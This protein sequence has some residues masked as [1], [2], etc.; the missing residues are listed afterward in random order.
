MTGNRNDTPLRRK[1][2]ALT[3]SVNYA[4]YLECIAPNIRHFDRWLIVTDE[5]DTRTQEVC[6]RW[7]MEILLSKRLY[8]NGAVFHKAAALNEGLA[9]LDQD[10]WVAVMDSDILLPHD[11]RSRLDAQ[12]L[13][14][15]CLYGLGGRRICQTIHDFQTLAACEPWADNLIYTTFVIGYF[16]LFHLGQEKNRYPEES[17]DDAS[18]YDVDFSESFAAARRRYL[19][20]V[21]LHAGDASQNWRGRVTDPFFEEGT[22]RD[23]VPPE[24]QSEKI[25]AMLGGPRTTAVQIGCYR[26]DLTRTLARSFASVV[27]IDH[28]G[29]LVSSPSPALAIDL[30]LLARRYTSETKG[31]TNITPPLEHSDETLATIAD[32]SL[33]V[34]WLT[35]EPEY[36]FLLNFLPAW[37][38]KLKPG[39]SIVGG[40]YDPRDLPGP[41]RVVHLLLGP[42]DETF[43]DRQWIRHLGEP[44]QF[45]AER[46][47]QPLSSLPRQ[48]VIYVS[49][50]EHDVEALLVSLS[51]LRRHWSGA[52]CVLCAGDENPS[53]RLACLKLNVEFRNVPCVSENYPEDLNRLHALE[54]SPFEE[55]VFIDANTLVLDSPQF[56]FEALAEHD[57][58]FC[59][60]QGRTLAPAAMEA[61]AWHRR[62]TV[63]DSWRTIAAA[64][65]PLTGLLATSHGIGALVNDSALHLLPAESLWS[66]PAKR[67]PPGVRILA[68]PRLARAG[69]LHLY[70][71]WAEQEQAL[72][73]SMA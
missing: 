65:L 64:M 4:D 1:I 12:H 7:G 35:A 9:A 5:K 34:I 71:L 46:F 67:M 63:I 6:R 14:P 53:L 31:L 15:A 27:V 22:L 24:P 43:P 48:G 59:R 30:E 25:A 69:A 58:G 37:L 72:L 54:W 50:G 68:L 44:A 23:T 47:R 41:S 52:V 55:S 11:F 13:D 10:A 26:G 57:N 21:C 39:G 28:W 17:S 32:G 16:N 19:P 73:A 45:A 42:P 2:Q 62:S 51:S 56:L 66:G 49:M 61:F 18:C 20:F 33:D 70:P 29:L 38:P 8:E 36:D 60:S 3:V 40:F